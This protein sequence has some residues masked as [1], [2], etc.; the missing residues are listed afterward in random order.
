VPKGSV[1]DTLR[2]A[3]QVIFSPAW[4]RWYPKMPAGTRPKAGRGSSSHNSKAIPRQQIEFST[5][6]GGF[7]KGLGVGNLLDKTPKGS[8]I[9]ETGGDGRQNETLWEMSGQTGSNIGRRQC[10]L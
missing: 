4:R 7:R 5:R 9:M 6:P 10:V 3:I 1:R 2:P 8:K